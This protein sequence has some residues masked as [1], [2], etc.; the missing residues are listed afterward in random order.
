[1]EQPDGWCRPILVQATHGRKKP[2]S[3]QQQQ[4]TVSVEDEI[5]NAFRAYEAFTH[6][7][8]A[9]AAAVLVLAEQLAHLRQLLATQ[10]H[11]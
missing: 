2:M 1:M 3:E 11:P 8:D 4:P 7:K 10:R 9:T 5:R 6:R